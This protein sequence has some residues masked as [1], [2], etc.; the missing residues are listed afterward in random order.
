MRGPGEDQQAEPA[1]AMQARVRASFA[2]QAMMATLGAELVSIEPGRVEL[3]L[4]HDDKFTQQHGFVHAGAVAAVLDSACGYA[5]FS[6][7]PPEAAVLTAAY[8]INLLAPAAGE[9]FRMMG[10]V[11]RAG[12][13]LVVCRGDAFA[14]GAATPF[15]VM[16]ATL[17]AL[18]DRPGV[19]H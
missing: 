11:I 19:Q 14:D 4:P 3:T 10:T 18:Y 1:A 6:V 2:R 5:A 7:M 15:A 8:T 17:T 16:Q 13:T 9:R 12:R